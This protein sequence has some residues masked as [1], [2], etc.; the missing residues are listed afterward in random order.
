MELSLYSLVLP[1]FNSPILESDAFVPTF[2]FPIM[3]AEV[4]EAAEAAEA[5]VVLKFTGSRTDFFFNY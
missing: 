2:D 3:E 5:D 1:K 4:A